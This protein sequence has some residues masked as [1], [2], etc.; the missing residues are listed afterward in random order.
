MISKD[1]PIVR[2][3][4]DGELDL[5]NGGTSNNVG[6]FIKLV[7]SITLTALE[8][9]YRAIDCQTKACAPGGWP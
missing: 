3:L 9:I 8:G 2:E 1:F 5:A 6:T 7:N 4:T